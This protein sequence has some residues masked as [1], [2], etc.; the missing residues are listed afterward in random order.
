M[1]SKQNSYQ[2]EKVILKMRG[3]IQ[4]RNPLIYGKA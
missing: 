4:G 1:E 2:N 3:T